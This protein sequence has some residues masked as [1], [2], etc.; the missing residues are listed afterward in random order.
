MNNNEIT[1]LAEEIKNNS[2]S[3]NISKERKEKIKQVAKQVVEQ[4]SED[5]KLLK[6]S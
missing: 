2:Y 6:D 5:I 1:K 3:E 4:Y